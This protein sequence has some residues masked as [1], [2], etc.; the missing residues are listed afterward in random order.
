MV[1]SATADA[2]RPGALTTATPLAL[3]AS[4]S[5]LTGPPRLTPISSSFGQRSRIEAETGARWVI[6]TCAS[7]IM[8]D[9]LVGL[10]H[11]LLQARELAF[12]A[13]VDEGLVRPGQLVQSAVERACRQRCL[14]DLWRHEAVAD[15]AGLD[16]A[17]R[18]SARARQLAGMASRVA[19]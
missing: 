19:T 6:S 2:L 8:P 7:P 12:L 10:A 3:H 18:S 16:H 13:G 4:R 5:M 1:N 14:E 11:E 9:D 17:R 15:D